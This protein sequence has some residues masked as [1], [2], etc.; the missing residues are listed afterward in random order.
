MKRDPSIDQ[1][2][3]GDLLAVSPLNF[4]DGRDEM[5]EALLDLLPAYTQRNPTDPGIALHEALAAVLE[6]FGFYHDRI[7]TESKVGAAQ[8]LRSVALLGDVVG[9]TP[10]PALA[11]ITHQFFEAR[12]LGVIA[13]GSKLAA[14]A[15]G[16]PAKVIFETLH[17]LPI[18]PAFNRMAFDPIIARHVGAMRAVIRRINESVRDPLTPLDEFPAGALAMFN[19][20]AGLEL[21]PISGARSRAVAVSR[22]LRHSY[23]LR[24]ARIHCTTEFRR[25]R[26]G[27]PLA[28]PIEPVEQGAH[29]DLMVFEVTD[30]P[31]LHIPEP[32]AR[33]L[34]S[35]LEVYVFDKEVVDP[36]LWP[37]EQCWEEV[38]DFSA[39]EASDRHYRM[40]VDDRLHTYIIVRRRLGYRELLTETQLEHIYVRFTPAIGDIRLLY[41]E[42]GPYDLSY[43]LAHLDVEYFTSSLVV[44]K[45]DGEPM[46][47]YPSDW[48]VTDHSLELIPGRQIIIE[49]SDTGEKFVRTLGPRTLG[50]YLSWRHNWDPTQWTVWL[51]QAVP[52]PLWDRIDAD[53]IEKLLDS[54]W[55]KGLFLQTFGHY[56][57]LGL[58]T[59]PKS[60]SESPPPTVSYP[61]LPGVGTAH[62]ILDEL[63][64]VEDIYQRHDTVEGW[65][66]R[67]ALSISPLRDAAKAG[68]YHLWDQF[69][70]HFEN[71]DWRL[72]PT[73]TELFKFLSETPAVEEGNDVELEEE[74]K[75]GELEPPEQDEPDEDPKPQT[76]TDFDQLKIHWLNA[77]KNN[78]TG[79]VVIVPRGAT[80]IIV[81]NSSLIGPG[82]Y[83]L[84]GKRLRY[85]YPK[86]DADSLPDEMVDASED[87]MELVEARA[88]SLALFGDLGAAPP[89]M[90]ERVESFDPHWMVAEILQAVEVHGRIVRLKWP[91][92]NQYDVDF[93][94]V[95]PEGGE[96]N[97]APQDGKPSP[98]DFSIEQPITEL[99]IVP[100]VASV[101]FGE[102]F[103]QEVTLSPSR[104]KLAN[105]AP[106]PSAP[107][108]LIRI[109][110]PFKRQFLRKA[111]GW[112]DL[113]ETKPLPG[114]ETIFDNNWND[115]FLAN[116]VHGT[117]WP[118]MTS[119]LPNTNALVWYGHV[120]LDMLV[121][122]PINQARVL[123]GESVISETDLETAPSVSLAGKSVVYDDGFAVYDV[124]IAGLATLFDGVDG[125]GGIHLWVTSPPGETTIKSPTIFEV[126]GPE[127]KIIAEAYAPVLKPETLIRLKI[128]EQYARI[129][130]SNTIGH[131]NI[132]LLEADEDFPGC[133]EFDIIAVDATKGIIR[134]S[135][136]LD[137]AGY[138]AEEALDPPV[139]VRGSLF[140]PVNEPN[141]DQFVENA[142]Y[143][144]PHIERYVAEEGQSP[145]D[146]MDVLAGVDQ[147]TEYQAFPNKANQLDRER[148]KNTGVETLADDKNFFYKRGKIKHLMLQES[149]NLEEGEYALF[150]KGKGPHAGK[151]G[152]LGEKATVKLQA[153]TDSIIFNSGNFIPVRLGSSNEF[154]HKVVANSL[155]IRLE[156]VN[157]GFEIDHQDVD[158][159]QDL[160]EALGNTEELG[161]RNLF[162]FGK[163]PEGVFT[164]NFLFM[165]YFPVTVDSAKIVIDVIYTA[166][167][168]H[169]EDDQNEQKSDLD[170]GDN[171]PEPKISQPYVHVASYSFCLNSVVKWKEARLYQF[172]TRPL[173]WNPLRQLV[174][175]NA[176]ELKA[177]DYLF[178]DPSGIEIE[179]DGPC[180][181]PP[182]Q[183]PQAV[184]MEAS[185][186]NQARDFIQ[187]TRVV[188]VDGRM[189]MVDPHVKIQPRGFYHYRVTGYRRPAMA[190]KP[191][192]DYYALLESENK[193]ES[194]AERGIEDEPDV[195]LKD[196]LAKLS[197][198]DRLMLQPFT[199]TQRDDTSLRPV[200]RTWLL[201][202][203]VPGDRLLVWDT[204]WKVAWA[205]YRVHGST[206][207]EHRWWA[208]P[209]Y[210]HEVVIKRVVPHLGI[211]DLERRMPARFGVEYMT[212]G[213]L[214]GS[215]TF[216]S[217]VAFDAL[218][219][220]REPFQGTR[221][222][223]AIGDGDRR[224]KFP[225]FTSSV[226]AE[227]GLGSIALDDLGTVASNIET[228]TFDANAG[229]WARWSEFGDIDRAKRKDRAFVL[230]VETPNAP[231]QGQCAGALFPQDR[232]A[233][234]DEECCCPDSPEEPEKPEKPRTGESF[235]IGEPVDPPRIK[236]SISFGD[237][238]TGDLLPTG[239]A[240]VFIR[241]INIGVWCSH[242]LHRPRQQILRMTQACIP[243]RIESPLA[244]AKNLVL[245]AEHGAHLQWQS[246]E[247][248]S[249]WNSSVI[250]EID[251]DGIDDVE[252]KALV[253]RHPGP[254]EHR[255]WL[256]EVSDDQAREGHD[257]VVIRPIRPGVVELTVVMPNDLYHLL[258]SSA[259]L[260]DDNILS[261]IRVYEDLRVEQWRLDEKF[262]KTALTNDPTLSEGS[263]MVLLAESEGLVERS[264]LAFSRSDEESG[265]IEIGEVLAVDHSTYSAT[266]TRGLEHVYSLNRSYLFGNV[267]HAVQGNSERLVVGSGDGASPSL[268]LGL[269]NRE[270]I[271]HSTMQDS[272]VGE[273]TPGVIVLVDDIPWDRV[274][275]LEGCGPRERVYRLDIEASGKAFVSFGDGQSGAIPA[276]GL[277]N[278]VAVLRTGD[279]GRGNVPVGAVDRLLD[280]NL[281]VERTRNVTPGGGGKA[282]DDVDQAREHL[283][284][285]SFTH[286][287]VVTQDDVLRAVLALAN[288]VQARLD[289]SSSVDALRVIVALADR[290]PAE[291][292]VLEELQTRLQAVTPLSAGCSIEL[293]DVVQRPVHVVLD[294][295]L[296]R[297]FFEG[298]VILGL[299]RAFSAADDGFFDLRR[300][301]IGAPLRVGEIYEQVFSLPG[302]ATARV[303]WLSTDVAPLDLPTKVPDILWPKPDEVIRCD[304]D[305]VDD[306]YRARG[307]FRVQV[308]RGGK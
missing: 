257:G 4:A 134:A 306:P 45:V 93:N 123:R 236:L 305:R 36:N 184:D 191:D 24:D 308:K 23:G 231:K 243:F 56:F 245:L 276:A 5:L 30:R 41:P 63:L 118:V 138:S 280:G 112:S 96:D 99:I 213:V 219:F 101:F 259:G 179:S 7:L 91:T 299:E 42:P 261:R 108:Q 168:Y 9:Y 197:F 290:Q 262:Y 44:P 48:V 133:T 145:D 224:V 295:T 150:S 182:L 29:D 273:L 256:H 242:F 225:R 298:E 268:R 54:D 196:S 80:Y 38:P 130:E 156:M 122:L 254:I 303:R 223:L 251:V 49:N 193:K 253:E 249:L 205:A 6:T 294:V 35:T 103:S 114:W 64:F 183:P 162:N 116:F 43:H 78:P 255:I 113:N 143:P 59:S 293:V 292:F 157:S 11:A 141:S 154:D 283:M 266:L 297:G 232:D 267:V 250:V 282:A 248:E 247:G 120:Y 207:G 17:A 40:F 117:K 69:Y 32:T 21:T 10:R 240:N 81:Q 76:I 61:V 174:I 198:R 258:S 19:G 212:N 105:K 169:S 70:R 170:E 27:H 58:P 85:L 233:A 72:L 73:N 110:E 79:S 65:S 147:E 214:P 144:N 208:W 264:L 286:G 210:Q 274:A 215:R 160:V 31:I 52:R 115:M 218:K 188:E 230:G 166:E 89:K 279:G 84:L 18:G 307:S 15:A 100:Q 33:R 57:P 131:F 181:K 238:V 178:I 132:R 209:D 159:E 121:T 301:P 171:E 227:H 60:Q 300:W 187:W 8:L 140:E 139:F 155:R 172:E 244:S 88:H 260:P 124:G 53:I 47:I 66:D 149:S 220:Y 74:L 77:I 246:R 37:A 289:P 192:E 287:R 142:R 34:R 165:G 189:V 87:A 107:L 302:V 14:R 28:T 62:G 229:E 269:G 12:T 90:D 216:D 167:P 173:P 111:T 180:K 252:V 284:T 92:Q 125:I 95:Q 51:Q 152:T 265:D 239:K 158:Y 20:I 146:F 109:E 46:R 127:Y 270:P 16:A 271:L 106:A 175:L 200:E 68:P 67:T 234:A 228:L 161:E 153:L 202:N 26:N 203:L 83:F 75:K 148:Y 135:V 22:A 211:V 288:V 285:Q 136:E 278:I 164:L 235:P 163:T 50:Q 291:K 102:T 221:E 190:A 128:N 151:H 237:G 194:E 177:G 82:D 185:E 217:I 2:L 226:V 186:V 195:G 199:V 104:V 13:A 241:P 86:D 137:P 39:S 275:S 94:M 206:G 97:E 296:N 281:A 119:P 3:R 1:L 55:L 272:A 71:L 25:L 129:R 201:D 98:E 126:K 176:G 277:D 222:L 304:S 263:S 204:R